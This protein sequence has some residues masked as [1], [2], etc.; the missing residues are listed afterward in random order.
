[1]NHT[2]NG[3]EL[4]NSGKVSNSIYSTSYSRLDDKS[5]IMIY[6]KQNIPVDIR[7]KYIT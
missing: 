2:K 4:R 5:S 3:R 1:M 6:D 7:G